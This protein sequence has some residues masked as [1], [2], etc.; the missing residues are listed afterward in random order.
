M[1]T[2]V[3]MI[4]NDIIAELDMVS[5]ARFFT[6]KEEPPREMRRF[7]HPVPQPNRLRAMYVL[8][9]R[10]KAEGDN[11][12]SLMGTLHDT[13]QA[14]DLAR[15]INLGELFEALYVACLYDF[16]GTWGSGEFSELRGGRIFWRSDF[17]PKKEDEVRAQK[18]IWIEDRI[19]E[20]TAIPNKIK[21]LPVF[22]Y[23]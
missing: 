13:P 5:E 4:I 10:Y 21:I 9:E 3:E 2:L 11:A 6:G 18:L 1:H 19:A 17:P 20:V 12:R 16:Y 15:A 14:R 7:I 22:F 8:K 23:S